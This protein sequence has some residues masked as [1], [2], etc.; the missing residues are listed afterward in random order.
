MIFF[1]K[2]KRSLYFFLEPPRFINQSNP[3]QVAKH[4][5]TVNFICQIYG[6]PKPTVTWYKVIQHGKQTKD[7]ENLQLLLV[8]SQQYAYIYIYVYLSFFSDLG[9]HLKMLMIVRQVNINV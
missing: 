4:Y 5:S 7:N 2:D 3:L 6:V 9:L 8:N 1:K